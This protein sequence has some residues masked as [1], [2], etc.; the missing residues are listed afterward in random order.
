MT[1]TSTDAYIV[2]M[3]WSFDPTVSL[4][5]VLSALA[6]LAAAGG[7]YVKFRADAARNA[8]R[9]DTVADALGRL[10][11][12]VSTL[13]SLTSRLAGVVEQIEKRVER[14]ERVG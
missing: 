12:A 5:S 6:I 9:L 14:L 4:G 10:A 13:E 3:G 8:Y 1:G 2:H 11:A 7:A